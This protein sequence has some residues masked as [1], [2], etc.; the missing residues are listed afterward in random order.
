MTRILMNL[1]TRDD[2]VKGNSKLIWFF[3]TVPLSKE[4]ID[5]NLSIIIDGIQG[6]IHPLKIIRKMNIN[7]VFYYI[8][9][10]YYS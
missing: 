1:V 3:K 2:K 8:L 10:F 4:N 9:F 7:I 6:S 5:R